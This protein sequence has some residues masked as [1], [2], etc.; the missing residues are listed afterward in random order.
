MTRAENLLTRFC[1][2]WV[3]LRAHLI[4]RLAAFIF[5]PLLISPS[6]LSVTARSLEC[7]GSFF[8]QSWTRHGYGSALTYPKRT[9]T[10]F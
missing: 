4:E 8:I 9:K 10:V 5:L 2:V 1:H 6:A 3:T 7:F